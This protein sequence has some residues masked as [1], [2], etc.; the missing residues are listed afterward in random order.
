MLTLK[1]L[2]GHA[3]HLSS[4]FDDIRASLLLDI[5]YWGIETFVCCVSWRS[6]ISMQSLTLR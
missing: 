4:S 1:W 2:S 3:K 6:V 5:L